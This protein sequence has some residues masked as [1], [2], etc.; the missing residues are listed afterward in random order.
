[1]DCTF[2]PGCKGSRVIGFQYCPPHLQTPR[3]TQHALS[4]I[5]SG[6]LLTE[7]D[8]EMEI[9]RRTDVPENDYHTSAL[10]KMD[11][12]LTD[13]LDFTDRTKIMLFEI[14]ANDW[15]YSH[16]TAGEQTRMEVGLYERALDR[17]A[18]TLKDV[19]KMALEEK[20]TSLGRA[21]VELVIRILM[22][23]V[24]ELGLDSDTITRART[25]LL[26][27]FRDEANLSSRLEQRTEKQLETGQ[28]IDA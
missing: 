14:P 24:I 19:S 18:R 15:R 5:K 26:R 7:D 2:E 22:G 27:R 28:V 1:M 4:V 10:E 17:A 9:A 6:A 13:L 8:L 16:R 23:T 3:G 21:Q 12:T 11:K 20:I 25:I